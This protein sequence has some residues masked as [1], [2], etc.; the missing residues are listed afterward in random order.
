[1]L[2]TPVYKSKQLALFILS[3]F[4][5]VYG[6]ASRTTVKQCASSADNTTPCQIRSYGLRFAVQLTLLFPKTA[7]NKQ[8]TLLLSLL[9]V[10]HCL[11]S[12]PFRVAHSSLECTRW[13]LQT[14]TWARTRRIVPSVI[15]NHCRDGRTCS[16]GRRNMH[17]SATMHALRP[18]CCAPFTP[19][20]PGHCGSLVHRLRFLLSCRHHTGTAVTS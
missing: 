8:K 6:H 2:T 15:A 10:F 20:K 14:T 5:L 19:L 17:V 3:F 16:G 9:F 12:F 18:R 13:G 11:S 1:M 7:T 4:Y